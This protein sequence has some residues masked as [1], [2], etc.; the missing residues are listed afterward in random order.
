MPVESVLE[1][2]LN[3]MTKAAAEP[4]DV[5]DRS[6]MMDVCLSQ[7]SSTLSQYAW[8]VAVQLDQ[9]HD[10]ATCALA[11]ALAATSTSTTTSSTMS[12]E[13]QKTMLSLGK[14][15]AL[16]A[17]DNSSSEVVHWATLGLDVVL[18]CDDVQTFHELKRQL[19][20]H[21]LAVDAPLWQ[22]IVARHATSIHEVDVEKSMRS[23]VVYLAMKNAS[24]KKAQL[25]LELVDDLVKDPTLEG[26][27]I[28]A[29]PLLAKTLAL[30]V[31]PP[32]P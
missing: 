9:Y 18:S 16:A 23:S 30:V 25:T 20:R 27:S 21:A 1:A 22:Q 32:P 11:D 6:R 14:L 13:L 24:S 7:R 17:N 26:I 8:M 5:V 10:V 29:R 2:C 12:L 3:Q 19:W 31:V 28:K 4:Q 15:A